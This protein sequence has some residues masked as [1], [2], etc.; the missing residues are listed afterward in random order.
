MAAG[1]AGK[2]SPTMTADARVVR[3][4]AAYFGLETNVRSPGP[5]CS[6]PLSPRISVSGDPFSRRTSRA[7]AIAESFMDVECD[8]V[9]R[10]PAVDRIT[11][12]QRSTLRANRRRALTHT[13]SSKLLDYQRERHA[14]RD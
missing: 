11:V 9:N 5:A 8:D 10:T 1:I 12:A 2:L 3:A 14:V 7:A 6:I 13:Y 4:A